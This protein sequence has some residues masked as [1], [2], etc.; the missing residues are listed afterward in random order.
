MARLAFC[1]YHNMIAILEKYKHNTDFHQIVDFVDASHLRYALTINP[2][3]Y[4]SHSQQFWS[5]ARIETTNEG[6]KI[7]ATVDDK[8]ASPI[9][10]D[11]Q[12]KACPTD[13]GL[14]AE[15]DKANIS[16][17]STLPSDSTPRQDEMASK[18]TDQDLEI[19][20]LKAMIKHLEDREGRGI[21][22][23]GEDAP[24]KGRSLDEGE[25][26]AIER[27]TEKGSND[28]KEMVNVLTSLDAATVLSSGVSVSIS[29]VIEVS[30]AEVPT[31]SGSIPTA[32]PPGT[33]VPTGSSVVPTASPIFTIAT[34][35]TPSTRRKGKE[36]MVE[37]E[38]PNKKKLQEQMDVQMAR[39]IHAEEELQIM[40]DGLNRNNE[41]VA[42]YLK[43][44]HQFATELPIERRIELISDL[45]KYQYN[46]TKVLKYQTQ[47]RKP[48]IKK[49][50]RKFYM[51]VPRSHAGWKTRYFKG[52][53]LKEIKEKF[54]LVWK[55]NEDFIPIG[56]NEEG[57]R[58]KRKGLRLEQDSAKKGR[59]ESAMSISKRDSQHQT[60]HQMEVIRHNCGVHHVISKD[61]EMFML[62]ENDYPLRKGLAIVMISYKLQAFPLPVMSSHCQKKFPQLVKKVPSA[63]EKRCYC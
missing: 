17:T 57:E 30:V 49:Q 44:Y 13:F 38:T 33:G 27:S 37:S 3:V 4:V 41:T 46:Y 32:S 25:E 14:E 11:S 56:S 20:T 2:T 54:D 40:I 42:K 9:R 31:G 61:Q 10:D 53:T 19:A 45:V 5:T 59:F 23:S 7:L 1:D 29:P 43:E 6:T 35:T 18:I 16:K 34:V 55:Q 39:Q 15:Q 52:I 47:Q 22:Q 62:V 36:K 51:S 24:I 8:P 48:L 28:T 50:Q 63:E 60:S 58:F 21:V 26:A 12:G